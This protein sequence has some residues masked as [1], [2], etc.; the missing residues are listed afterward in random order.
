MVEPR[1]RLVRYKTYTSTGRVQL[2]YSLYHSWESCSLSCSKSNL[3]VFD[4]PDESPNNLVF[5]A[6]MGNHVKTH[7][8]RSE[9]HGY[10][11]GYGDLFKLGRPL[12]IGYFTRHPVPCIPPGGKRG[13]CTVKSGRGEGRGCIMRYDVCD[14]ILCIL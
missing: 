2:H 9:Y 4:F 7:H 3:T 11:Y 10:G 8:V 12:A 5:P 13:V 1:T 14:C 6:L